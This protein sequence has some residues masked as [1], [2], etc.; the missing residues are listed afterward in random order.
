MTS[1]SKPKIEETP[2][3][4]KART[5]FAK[6]IVE[7]GITHEFLVECIKKAVAKADP[8]ASKEEKVRLG[9][10]LLNVIEDGYSPLRAMG[11]KDAD[12]APVYS[13]AYSEFRA[14]KFDVAMGYFKVLLM[15]DPHRPSF[16]M[17]LGSC[18]HKLKKY[19]YAA[20]LY[21]QSTQF[22][23]D[24][25]PLP[26]YYCYDCFMNLG[27][28][29]SAAVMLANAIERCGDLPKYQ[30]MKQRC[31]LFLEQCVKTIDNNAKKAP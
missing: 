21:M 31:Q 25:D 19:E 24:S 22:G 27:D 9:K 15:L 17:A 16:C 20:V 10:V 14:G 13:L 30:P 5:E 18:F 4:L 29:G 6:Q 26:Y 12:I 7:S 8:K 23:G 28:V 1:Q 2:E 11:M 3:Y